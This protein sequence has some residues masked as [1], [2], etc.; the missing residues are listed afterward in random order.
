MLSPL[1]PLFFIKLFFVLICSN[2]KRYV[3]SFLGGDNGDIGDNKSIAIVLGVSTWW[4]QRQNMRRQEP[5][6]DL[7]L[8]YPPLNL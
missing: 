7:D 4:R 1:S 6:S 5:T 8:V 3:F 2:Y